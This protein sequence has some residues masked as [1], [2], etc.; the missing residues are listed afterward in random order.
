MAELQLGKREQT[1]YGR[2]FH[3]MVKTEKGNIPITWREPT[4]H[5]QSEVAYVLSTG[6]LG[7]KC[8]MRIPAHEAVRMGHVAV[9]FDYTNRSIHH[10]VKQNEE[11]LTAVIDALP[12][13][14][15]K[16]AIGLSMGGRVL[17]EALTKTESKV[18]IAT[19]VASAG[20]IK[21]NTSRLRALQH[22][23]ATAPEAID[24]LRR[25]PIHAWRLGASV[26]HNCIARNVAVAAEINDLINGSVRDLVEE[27]KD[28]PQPPYLRFMYGE[29]DKLLPAQLQI[30]GLV[31]LPFDH[32]E[33]YPGGHLDLV[34]HKYLARRIFELDNE[35]L[36]SPPTPAPQAM[37]IAA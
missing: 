16:N 37:R 1:N 18:Q 14:L 23:I 19:M 15:R 25:D 33:P 35:V 30:E 7:E 27:I 4:K 8:S 24:F 2:R 31:D 17:T 36:Q 21:G 10:P 13:D 11:S 3:G 28:Q 26:M 29:R 22:F 12:N 5:E 9:S 20:Y 6:W 34:R 32:I